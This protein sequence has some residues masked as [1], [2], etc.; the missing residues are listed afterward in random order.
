MTLVNSADNG[1]TVTNWKLVVNEWLTELDLATARKA[2][3]IDELVQ[4]LED[5]YQDL[6]AEG[7]TEARASETALAELY[8]DGL[9]VNDL[10]LIERRPPTEPVV[11]GANRNSITAGVLQDL[12]YALRM[13][14]K[15]RAV[16]VVAVITM[17]LGIGINTT[18]FGT[19]QLLVFRPFAFDNQKR[20][21][22][23]WEQQPEAGLRRGLVAPGNF[24]DWREQSYEFEQ[25]VA[26][27]NDSFDLSAGDQPERFS[28]S[29]VSA[30]FFDALG[31]NAA[32]G[33]IFTP[34]ESQSADQPVVVLKHSL[35]QSRFG[36]DSKIIGRTIKLNGQHFMVVGVMPRT[37]DFPV[38]GG[39]LWVPLIFEPQARTDR[40]KHFLQVIGLPRPGVTM[41]QASEELAVIAQRAQQQY[42]ETNRGR[43]VRV[44]SLVQYATRGARVGAPF[45]FIS[46]LLVLLVA[47]ANVAN[48]L[49]VRAASRKRDIAIRLAL[50]ASRFRVMRQLFADSLVLASLG[51]ALG[52]LLSI[53][54]INTVRGIPQDFSRFIP[55]WE[56]M[57]IDQAALI[58][59][60][61]VSVTTG[62]LCGLMPALASARLNLNAA[63]KESGRD[64]SGMASKFTPHSLLVIAEVAI[65][66]VLLVGAGLMLRSFAELARADLGIKPTNVLTLQVSLEGEKYA[67]EQ[68]RSD[69]YRM[70]LD[71][72]ASLPDVIN[73]GAVGTL[74]LGYTYY[75]R[76]VL[77]AGV[78]IFRPQERPSVTWRVATPGYFG[79]IGT[80]LR[81]GRSFT[82]QD[83]AGGARLALV[84]EALAKQFFPNQGVI[85]QYLR[86][87]EGA[88]YQIIGVVANVLNEDLEEQAEPE[89]YAPYA[90]DPWRTVY[91]VIRTDSNP[92]ALI[93]SVRREVGA[94][95]P[96]TPIFNVKLMEQLVAERLSPKKMAVYGLG[97]SAL[98]A[99]LLA[100]VGIYSVMSYSVTQR[101]REIGLR[102][103]LGAQPRDILK[104]VIRGGLK[105]VLIGSAIGLFGAWALTRLLTGLLFG[106]SAQDPLAFTALALLLISV[107]LVACYIPARRAT[108]VDPLIALR[109]PY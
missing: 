82:E 106:V 23:I 100:A 50:G 12:R 104:L 69:H 85:G 4:H 61:V 109:C 92:A 33:R 19:L 11:L 72:L 25:L 76:E 18:V 35:W 36:A 95:D 2:E 103:A 89:V 14:V 98:I 29:R 77:S 47:C 86:C 63:L 22:M 31:A 15:Q 24:L 66:L 9:L 55:G 51:G 56:K 70:L 108:K 17:A 105:L 3:I 20:L 43:T 16:T 67:S 52:L 78:T 62:L 32:I 42:P 13:L 21:L 46:G 49:L 1:S 88:P 27:S 8:R 71:R 26:V 38:G 64:T 102:L 10:R 91:L 65:S 101:T 79:A 41:D 93:T 48:L 40:S 6:L 30:G 45:M 60:L 28:G 44:A 83:R 59:T 81:Q 58:F 75:N 53:W 96:T 94:M 7:F 34:A 74:P 68:A 84:N 97:C 90:Q 37:F 5:R 57:G 80:S 54:S 87:D 99:L 73:V 39:E 107:A